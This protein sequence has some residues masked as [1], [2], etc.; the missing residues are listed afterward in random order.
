MND[1]AFR[2][3]APRRRQR[4]LNRGAD[5]AFQQLRGTE[6]RARAPGRR[7]SVRSRLPQSRYR[8]RKERPS[9]PQ[10]ISLRSRSSCPTIKTRKIVI[11]QALKGWSFYIYP[12]H[13]H[14]EV[15]LPATAA[16]IDTPSIP[17]NFSRPSPIGEHHVVNTA[18][19]RPR[20]CLF[21]SKTAG[22]LLLP[23]RDSGRTKALGGESISPIPAFAGT[24]VS[25]FEGVS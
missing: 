1:V 22:Y 20:A 13:P 15:D 11:H 17:R 4:R 14:K 21:A 5:P 3:S 6:E 9:D 18:V 2:G 23:S 7:S 19:D 16:K 10:S 8:S 25:S 24:K 12:R